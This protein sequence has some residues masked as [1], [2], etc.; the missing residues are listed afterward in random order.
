MST[1][2]LLIVA[3]MWAA[4]LLPPIF[5]S[6]IDRPQS[7]VDVFRRQLHTLQSGVPQRGAY[8]SP[9]PYGGSAAPMRA[10]ARPFAPTQSARRASL[11]AA[12]VASATGGRSHHHTASQGMPRP[13][14]GQVGFAPMSGREMLR[15]RRT[16]V[17]Y[18]ILSVNGVSLFLAF[19][20]GSSLMTL[21]FG[22]AFLSL[23]GY[24][25]MLVQ[26]RQQQINRGY[27]HNYYR[28]A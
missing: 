26:I 14:N 22:A 15:R 10:M 16:N 7:S 12:P 17:L 11:G 6:K 13:V 27:R 1:V 18:G 28:A 9:S 3:A 4:V 21:I 25:Y 19:T 24:C 2:I 8:G 23:V 5:R 20:T